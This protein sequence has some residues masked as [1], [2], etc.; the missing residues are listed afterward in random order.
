MQQLAVAPKKL[1]IPQQENC[2]KGHA[3]E[4]N[5]AQGKAKC[6]ICLKTMP[7]GILS[8]VDRRVLKTF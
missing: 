3:C 6:Y 5:L 1:K 4:A 2:Y 8:H 7:T